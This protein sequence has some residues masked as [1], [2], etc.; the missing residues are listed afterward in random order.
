MN[1][2][3]ASAALLLAAASL[4]A[5]S[6]TD[7]LRRGQTAFQR[8][9][10]WTAVDSYR[11]ALKANPRYFDALQGLA[12]SFFALG[13][14][15]E[16]AKQVQAA[17]KLGPL[18]SSVNV[19]YGR[20]LLGQMQYEQAL[21]QFQAVLAREPKNRGARF[22]LAEYEV[23][24][25]RLENASAQF[26]ALRRDDPTDIRS[27]LSLLYVASARND[28][29]GFDR[30]LSDALRTHSEDA[31][32]HFAAAEEMYRRQDRVQARQFLDQFLAVSAKTDLRGWYLQT[33]LLLDEGRNQDVVQ[34]LDS[35]IIQAGSRGAKEPRAWYLRALALSRLD[36]GAEASNAFRM[37]LGFDPS[38]EA[39]AM[40]YES[41]L[42]RKTKPEDPLRQAQSKIHL[43]RAQELV[44]KNFQALALD[45]YRRA[46]RLDPFS[47]KARLG[48]AEIWKRQGLKT[49]SLEELEAVA[50]QNPNYKDVAFADDL[51]IQRSAYPDSLAGQ[52]GFSLA[53]LDSLNSAGTS[54]LYR[55]FVVGVFYDPDASS[56]A[57]YGAVE[58]YAEA[59]ADEWDSLRSMQVTSPSDHLALPAQGFNDAFAQ[60]RTS[61]LEYFALVT[62]KEGLRDFSAQVG[63]YLGRTGRLIQTFTVYKKGA[64]PVTL[65][66]RELA[67]T[68]AD[69][70]PLRGS[71]LKRQNADVLVNLGKR[72][73]TA[74]GQKFSVVRDG[75]AEPTG[76]A[77]W[78]TWNPTDAFGTWTAGA[79]DDWTTAGK[80]EK[81]GFFDTVAVG[82][83]VL[84]V[85]DPPKV[86]APVPLP[87]SAVL[88]RD[89]LSL[90]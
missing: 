46:L 14:Y 68:A 3:L 32:V 86:A 81:T 12:E 30:V 54:R 79:S 7:A 13:E 15:D 63:L 90:R 8:D 38:N 80:L 28:R 56:T 45:E 42:L 71:I 41:W 22:G 10:Y 47:A 17:L 26:E 25:G 52:W 70:F 35:K 16:A 84:F 72:D 4:T 73:G 6:A 57:D 18:S 76:D 82:D 58:G 36:R 19:L 44:T 66:L 60:A 64:L 11:D 51:E 65:G 62:F 2:V 21:A 34:T 85:K 74:E 31:R 43:D 83:E 67:K 75:A 48:R 55:P 40:A 9:D 24:R 39:F 20:I 23:M 78:F 88:Q 53:D 49:S 77:S 69:A 1:R 59:F 37:A 89:I 33:R 87:V 27:Q 5:Q 29:P 50:A 61:S